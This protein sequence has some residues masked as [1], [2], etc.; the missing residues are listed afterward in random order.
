MHAQLPD[1]VAAALA[2]GVGAFLRAMPTT[3]I[4]GLLRR[5]QKF[6]PQGLPAHS[7]E[8]IAA[9]DDKGLRARIVEWLDDEKPRLDKKEAELLRIACERRH[10]W[11]EELRSRPRARPRPKK[12]PEETEASTLDRERAKAR[13]ARDEARR[14]KEER[15]RIRRDKRAQV[16]E[17]KT[18]LQELRTKVTRAEKK[19][20]DAERRAEG[21][22]ERLARELRKARRDVDSARAAR[23]DYRRRARD[24]ERDARSLSRRVSELEARTIPRRARTPRRP[25]SAPEPDHRTPLRAPQGRLED[26]PETLDAWLSEPAVHL[27]VDGYNATKHATGWPDAPLERQRELLEQS[28]TRLVRRKKAKATI[29]WDG[30]DIPPG[31]GR[32]GRGAVRVEYSAPDES[33][34]DHLVS[35][36]DR[37]SRHPVIVA[38]SDRELQERARAERATIATSPQLLGLLR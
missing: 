34:D 37:L 19:A 16:S 7:G 18:Q 25:A 20:Q 3:E 2:R 9:L 36:L 17:L 32:G 22:E 14:A 12:K 24:A 13:K 21:A 6:R 38:T 27:V 28:V 11:E 5:F 33:A 35:L 30:S 31:T 1:D 29:V 4:P 10:G 26:A 15:D 8:L 23:D